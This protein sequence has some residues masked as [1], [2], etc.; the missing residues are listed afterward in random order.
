MVR[1]I[2]VGAMVQVHTVHSLLSKAAEEHGDSPALIV[3][4]VS[5]LSHSE[6]HSAIEKT[7]VALRR[8][9]VKPGDLVSLAFPNTLEVGLCFSFVVSPCNLNLNFVMFRSW[10][11]VSLKEIFMTCKFF[12]RADNLGMGGWICL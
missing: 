4:N 9:G 5:S 7:A 10:R 3:P 1:L 8:A 12:R 11:Y 6:L 2:E